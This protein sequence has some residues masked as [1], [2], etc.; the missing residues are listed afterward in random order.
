MSARSLRHWHAGRL[1]AAAGSVIAVLVSATTI[2]ATALVAGAVVRV[3]DNP[4]GGSPTCAQLVAQQEGLGSI[5]YPDAEVEP[6]VAVDPTNP[7]HLVASFQ[8]DRWNDGGANGLTHVVSTDG[9]ASWALAA[10]QPPFS[11]CAGATSGAPGFFHRATDP[12][13]SF[14]ADGQVVYSI[15]A[16]FDANGP[17]FGG[18]S[19]IL[20][21]RSTDGGNH[22][23]TPVTLQLDTSFTVLND[24]ESITADPSNAQVA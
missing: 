10:G 18:A 17:G 5:N 7:Q 24:K 16:S 9:G 13:V 8:Q 4:L 1:G 20:V 11:V 12:W 3:P 23:Q 21:S 14:S 6:Y 19:A 15:S 22:W 2:F